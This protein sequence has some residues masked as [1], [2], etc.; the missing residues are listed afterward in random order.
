MFDNVG[1]ATQAAITLANE[2]DLI[3]G[4]GSLSVVAEIIEKVKGIPPELY[5]SFKG[6]AFR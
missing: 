2:D 3:I 6:T 5:P 4:T 1:E